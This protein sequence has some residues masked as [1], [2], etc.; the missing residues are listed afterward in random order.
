LKLFSPFPHPFSFFFIEYWARYTLVVSTCHQKLAITLCWGIAWHC[1]D[2]QP[3]I[4]H[5]K[6]SCLYFTTWIIF[7][8]WVAIFEWTAMSMW[9]CKSKFHI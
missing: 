8:N 9:P 4:V 7:V 2:H 1:Y 3:P 6:I 5:H